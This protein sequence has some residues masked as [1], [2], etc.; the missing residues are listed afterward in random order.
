ME[1]Y[2]LGL[3]LKRKISACNYALKKHRNLL[4]NECHAVLK[5]NLLLSVVL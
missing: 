3:V 1:H 5:Y 4:T 2:N